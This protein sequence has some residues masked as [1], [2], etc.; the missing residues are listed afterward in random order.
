MIRCF[1]WKRPRRAMPV[2]L[3]LLIVIAAIPQGCKR[4]GEKEGS[5][6]DM[7]VG[8]LGDGKPCIMVYVV[9]ETAEHRRKI[10]KELE[11]IPVVIEVSGEIRPMGAGGSS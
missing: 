4:S 6:P 10:P 1:G 2:L 3:I 9:K 11:G 7:S 5:V 8:A